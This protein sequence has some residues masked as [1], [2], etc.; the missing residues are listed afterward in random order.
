MQQKN[1]EIIEAQFGRQGKQSP[2]A[3][4]SGNKDS[5]NDRHLQLKTTLEPRVFCPEG[6]EQVSPGHRPGNLWPLPIF[7]ALK[8]HNK[9][10]AKVGL[11]CPFRAKK[12]GQ[13]GIPRTQGDALGTDLFGPFGAKGWMVS[14]VP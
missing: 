2:P 13:G 9:G 1:S 6:A 3:Y 4:Y 8:G 5:H 14:P 11:L 7:F 12:G 10:A